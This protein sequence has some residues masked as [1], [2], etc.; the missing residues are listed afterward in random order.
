[1]VTLRNVSWRAS[2]KAL[3]W[4][5]V[6]TIRRV[7]LHRPTSYYVLVSLGQTDQS[8]WSWLRQKG[9]TLFA[10]R[11]WPH[12]LWPREQ[13]LWSQMVRAKLQVNFDVGQDF[14][15]CENRAKVVP[16]DRVTKTAVWP[17]CSVPTINIVSSVFSL[18]ESTLEKQLST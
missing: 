8:P 13:A 11:R 2:W 15:W 4:D 7:T 9:T 14:F 5:K 10:F 1:M 3:R 12:S 6:I 16:A 18:A 17:K